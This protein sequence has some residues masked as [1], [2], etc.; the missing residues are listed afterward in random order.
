M[1]ADPE[2]AAEAA[3]SSLSASSA[4]PGAGRSSSSSVIAASTNESTSE[5]KDTRTV[6][7]AD[8]PPRYSTAPPP[9][10]I[11]TRRQWLARSQRRDTYFISTLA[12]LVPMVLAF[13]CVGIAALVDGTRSRPLNRAAVAL[14]ACVVLSL[15]PD[16]VR[17]VRD[18]L[19]FWQED[20]WARVIE[21]PKFVYIVRYYRTGRKG[22]PKVDRVRVATE[23]PS[24]T[25]GLTF[26]RRVYVPRDEWL[27]VRCLHNEATNWR[28][29]WKG[30]VDVEEVKHYPRA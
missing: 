13:A 24:A 25:S 16:M 15:V 9:P 10:P 23:K 28:L 27:D 20:P 3:E 2:W 11:K 7:F 12:V 14:A 8:L 5:H 30:P 19:W 22:R 4:A 29:Y 18:G 17:A 6:R 26:D 21:P 1:P